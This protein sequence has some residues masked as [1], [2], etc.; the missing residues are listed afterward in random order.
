MLGMHKLR[1]YVIIVKPNVNLCT[2]SIWLSIHIFFSSIFCLSIFFCLPNKLYIIK[3]KYKYM[4]TN[5]TSISIS[6]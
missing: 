3:Y 1:R 6:I 5:N 2:V 4:Y